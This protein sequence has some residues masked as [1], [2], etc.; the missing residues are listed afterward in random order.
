MSYSSVFVMQLII[1]SSSSVYDGMLGMHRPIPPHSSTEPFSKPSFD[2][3]ITV[4]CA[5]DRFIAYKRCD[6]GEVLSFW[7]W[8]CKNYLHN[9]VFGEWFSWEWYNGY[10]MTSF[11]CSHSLFRSIRMWKKRVQRWVKNFVKCSCESSLFPA[12]NSTWLTRVSNNGVFIQ[13]SIRR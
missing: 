9:Q 12:I 5:V 4:T 11:Y 6:R 10:K 1:R 7:V 2:T 8:L 13:L 3:Y